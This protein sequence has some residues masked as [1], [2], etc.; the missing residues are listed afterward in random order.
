MGE[1]KDIMNLTFLAITAGAVIV[2]VSPFFLHSVSSTI[3][4]PLPDQ[5][6][7]EPVEWEH[8]YKTE[9]VVATRYN[10]PHLGYNIGFSFPKQPYDSDRAE[11]FDF[12]ASNGCHVYQGGGY[13]GAPLYAVCNGVTDKAT[14]N[15]KLIELLPKLD[16]H[17][18]SLK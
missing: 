10:N 12:L 1:R 16:S 13:P 3:F 5:S 7:A 15:T 2:I 6:S 14:A 4:A 8:G 9:Y 18:K 11:T 17:M